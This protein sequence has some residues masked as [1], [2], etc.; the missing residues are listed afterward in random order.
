MR[1]FKINTETHLNS[2]RRMNLE[3]KRPETR[4][5]VVAKISGKIETKWPELLCFDVHLSNKR[6][7][8]TEQMQRFF[9][10]QSRKRNAATVK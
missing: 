5:L 2:F 7:L 10:S 4:T 3:R 1:F 8:K 9:E 6:R